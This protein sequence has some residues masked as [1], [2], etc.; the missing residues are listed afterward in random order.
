M[1]LTPC[2]EN[3]SGINTSYAFDLAPRCGAKTRTRTPCKSPAIRFKQRCRMHG[4]K[5]SGAPLGN[6]NAYKHGIHSKESVEERRAIRSIL[7]ECKIFLKN[8]ND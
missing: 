8:T 5:N 6:R 3:K 2:T 7:N 4:G 1:K